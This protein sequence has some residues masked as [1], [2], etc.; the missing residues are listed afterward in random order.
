MTEAH[1][2]CFHVK[3]SICRRTDATTKRHHIVLLVEI[4]R[5]F[6]KINERSPIAIASLAALT[7]LPTNQCKYVHMFKYEHAYTLTQIFASHGKISLYYI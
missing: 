4:P 6:E 3:E 7:A 2:F 5:C 1:V